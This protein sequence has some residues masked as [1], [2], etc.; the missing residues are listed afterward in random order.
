MKTIIVPVDFSKESLHGLEMALL[1]GQKENSN[2][3]MVYVQKSSKDYRPG[4]YEE[5]HKYAE[6]EFDVRT[7]ADRMEA[8]LW[9]ASHDRE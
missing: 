3:Q 9:E 4:T 7:L 2:I 8:M 1:F 6:K 5:E